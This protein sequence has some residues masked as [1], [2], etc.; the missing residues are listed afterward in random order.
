MLHVR[1]LAIVAAALALLCPAEAFR[2]AGVPRAGLAVRSRSAFVAMSDEAPAAVAD[3]AVGG[4]EEIEVSDDEARALQK[5]HLNKR[6]R[7]AR[8]PTVDL[9]ELTVGTVVEG[10]VKNVVSYGA[11]V[12][13]GAAKDGMLHVS[14]ISNSFVANITDVISVGDKISAR[15][16][17][18]DA[19]AG[20]FALIMKDESAEATQRP[21]RASGGGARQARGKPDLSALADYDPKKMMSGKVVSVMDF[22]C[23]VS[24]GDS[25]DG[26]VHISQLQDGRTDKVSD[27]VNIGD[28]VRAAKGAAARA[29]WR[30]RRSYRGRGRPCCARASEG[31]RLG[32]TMLGEG[33]RARTAV[34]AGCEQP[35][36]RL[37]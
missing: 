2:G 29:R 35:G 9:N 28:E 13:I 30:S 3:V 21:P 14:D 23:F 32:S 5:T 7:T 16:K 12:D 10:T 31:R 33:G 8:E 25:V 19:P 18:V 6:K 36:S 15:V 34:W 20:R 4:A 24:I 27:V 37:P 17:S 26:L 22:G 11:F 1:A